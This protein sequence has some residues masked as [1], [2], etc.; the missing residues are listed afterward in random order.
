[1]IKLENVYKSF[2]DLEV[3]KD[4]NLE[5]KPGE[6]VCVIGPSGSGKSTMLRCLNQLE[7]IT[8]GKIY[9]DGEL[10]DQREMGKDLQDIPAEKAQELCTELGMVF[11]RFN[12]FPHLTVYENITIAPKIVKKIKEEDI[13]EV[14]L[15]LLKLVGLEDKRDEYPSRLSGGQQQRVAI[16]RA[17]AM[18]PK[19][20]LFDEP[21]SALDPE[22]VG[23]VLEVM[24]KL[25]KDGMTMIVV[26]HEMG[27]AKE[28]GTRVI[29][30]D[31]GRIVEEGDPNQIFENPQEDRTKT[32]LKKIL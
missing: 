6:V 29:F 13:K 15:D 4:I 11:Q 20:M 23:E 16:A 17:L 14:A 31:E 18:Q 1:M 19:I 27:F 32:F 8:S 7:R 21:T 22:L 2:G 9:I 25:A 3:L 5:V 10:A 28:V 24:K 30:M 26:T 12:L